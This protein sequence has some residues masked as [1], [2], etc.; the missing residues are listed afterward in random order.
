MPFVT[1]RRTAFYSQRPLDVRKMASIE[2]RPCFP[3]DVLVPDVAVHEQ[4]VIGPGVAR[5]DASLVATRVGVVRW[6][7]SQT[8]LWVES[9]LKR[10][11]PALNDHVIGVV[12]DK[13]A[14]E[15]K[16]DI[17]T[18]AKALLPVLAFDGA[19]KRNRPH[20]AVRRVGACAALRCLVQ[21]RRCASAV[22]CVGIRSRRL[23]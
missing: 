15:Y 2:S 17:G 4:L 23:G 12:V 5:E 22:G 19:S 20:L 7:E 16:L 14:E 1:S 10:Y 3:G 21:T 9:D 11:W 13:G 8:L 18:A 6:E